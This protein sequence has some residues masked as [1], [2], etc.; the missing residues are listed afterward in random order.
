MIKSDCRLNHRRSWNEI[1][2]VFF[3]FLFTYLWRSWNEIL[4]VFFNFLFTYLWRSWNEILTVF[5][6]FLFTYLFSIII[7]LFFNF[8]FYLNC[9]CSY[10]CNLMLPSTCMCRPYILCL[11]TRQ[12]S[13]KVLK[14][15]NCLL[16]TFN[17]PYFHYVIETRICI[18]SS[19]TYLFAFVLVLCIR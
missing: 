7:S 18:N 15:Y 17:A 14:L 16:C 6:N 10:S 8:Y 5:F 3:N 4:T 12:D 9:Y 11:S 2:T 13:S 19:K 1:L